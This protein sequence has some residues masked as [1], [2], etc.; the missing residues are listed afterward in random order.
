MATELVIGFPI[1][2]V[3][4]E[5]LARQKCLFAT[6]LAGFVS[7]PVNLP[8]FGNIRCA[9]PVDCLDLLHLLCSHAHHVFIAQLIS[10]SLLQPCW[11]KLCSNILASA[12][13]SRLCNADWTAALSGARLV[14]AYLHFALG[15]FLQAALASSESRGVCSC[16]LA[17]RLA[18]PVH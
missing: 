5:L 6:W 15:P 16:A 9:H 10:R 1:S 13:S 14:H 3:T 7:L 18:T 8:G 11:W 12:E 4:Q 2:Y 17:I